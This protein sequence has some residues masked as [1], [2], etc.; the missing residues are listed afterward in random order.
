M[1]IKKM[2]EENEQLFPEEAVA[3]APRKRGRPRKNPAPEAAGEI[4]AET[5]AAPVDAVS[6]SAAETEPKAPRQSPYFSRKS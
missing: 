3:P 5:A 6:A 1:K 4:A 2:N